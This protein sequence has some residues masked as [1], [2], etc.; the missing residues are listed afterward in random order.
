MSKKIKRQGP[1]LWGKLSLIIAIGQLGLTIYRE[2]R[3]FKARR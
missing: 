3:Q 2:V 1:G